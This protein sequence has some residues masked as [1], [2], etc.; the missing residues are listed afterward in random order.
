MGSFS[1]LLRGWRFLLTPLSSVTPNPP[2]F[3]S[4]FQG[5]DELEFPFWGSGVL[6]E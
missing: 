3:L 2:A 5:V 4:V 6:D 1:Y